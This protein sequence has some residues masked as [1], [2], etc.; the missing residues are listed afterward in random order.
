[1][2]PNKA[3]TRNQKRA[4]QEELERKRR[5][6]LVIEE[7]RNPN[8]RERLRKIEG[9]FIKEDNNSNEEVVNL[10]L[11]ETTNLGET[12][13]INLPVVSGESEVPELPS[14]GFEREF[15]NVDENLASTPKSDTGAIPKRT[16]PQLGLNET[17]NKFFI[18]ETNLDLL[19]RQQS[20]ENQLR[21]IIKYEKERDEQFQL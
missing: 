8:I 4:L 13:I 12:T 16:Y 9:S 21:D 10:P 1:M 15:D 19:Q 2:D 18:N 7:L 20:L 17:G 3:K 6:A 14:V 11:D 5:A